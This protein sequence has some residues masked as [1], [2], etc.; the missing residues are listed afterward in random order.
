MNKQ[1]SIQV[2]GGS[3]QI[4]QTAPAL[5]PARRLAELYEVL[6][7]YSKYNPFTKAIVARMQGDLSL[8]KEAIIVGN[9]QLF[10]RVYNKVA[11]KLLENGIVLPSY[12]KYSFKLG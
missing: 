10:W 3:K 2:R 9:M 7:A 6:N 4:A 8:L 1:T 11:K 5:V 12:V